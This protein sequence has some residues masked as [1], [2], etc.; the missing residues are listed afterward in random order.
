LSF[1]PDSLLLKDT[2]FQGYEP[3][4]AR[5]L[6]PA[7][8]RPKREL[9]PWQKAINKVISKVRVGVEHA[10]CGVKRCRIVADVFRN[11]RSGF[12]DE[13][14]QVASGLHNLRVITRAAAA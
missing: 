3:P 2:G 6:Q 5:T 13:A 8:K 4:G 11:L 9:Y 12:V 1:P 7:K 10:I 14:M